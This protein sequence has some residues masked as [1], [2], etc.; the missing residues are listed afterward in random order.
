MTGYFWIGLTAGALAFGHCLG[1]CGG[2]VLQ[3]SRGKAR[4]AALERTLLWTLGRTS[5]YV[6]LGAM[7]GFVGQTA[8][9]RLQT[10]W[11]QTAL[12]YL[13]GTVMVFMGLTLLGAMPHRWRRPM[14]T[15]SGLLATLMRPLLGQPTAVG[16]WALGLVTGFMPCPVVMGLLALVVHGASVATGMVT[17]AAMGAGTLWSLLGLTGHAVQLRF[18]RWAAPAGA[19]VLVLLGVVTALRATPALHHWLGHAGAD[20]PGQEAPCHAGH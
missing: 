19:A 2:F 6:F 8:G 10:S 14:S 20:L 5:S 13:A 9:A 15:G 4:W 1:M 17:M 3:I 12:A 16:A 7:A 11:L 18:Q